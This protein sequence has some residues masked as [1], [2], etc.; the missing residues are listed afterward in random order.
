MSCGGHA[1]YTTKVSDPRKQGEA[2][3]GDGANGFLL[4]DKL[5][6][7]LS[8]KLRANRQDLLL[9]DSHGQIW[10][11]LALASQNNKLLLRG[12]KTEVESEMLDLLQLRDAPR[13]PISRLITL[14]QNERWQSIITRWCE[15]AVGRELFNISTWE[16]MASCRID[17][18]RI[19]SMACTRHARRYCSTLAPEHGC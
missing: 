15:T 19:C 3:E 10:T 5:P 9:P 13:F 8:T 12:K 7:G 16:W 1:S 4:A 11:Q 2:H 18:V 14:W 6:S 17:N